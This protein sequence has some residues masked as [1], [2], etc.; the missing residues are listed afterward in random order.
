[1]APED[2]GDLGSLF[3][4][5]VLLVLEVPTALCRGK[6]GCVSAFQNVLMMLPHEKAV[7][8]QRIS[9]LNCSC[10]SRGCG[11]KEQQLPNFPLLAFSIFLCKAD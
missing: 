7:R 2:L 11:G 9:V 6:R 3:L 10:G 8:K 4:L 1:M 5:A